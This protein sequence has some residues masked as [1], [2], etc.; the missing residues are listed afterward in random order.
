MVAYVVSPDGSIGEC[1]AQYPTHCRFHVNSDGTTMT[2]YA[3]ET[4]A[5]RHVENEA[6]R[7]NTETNY[8]N[9]LSKLRQ[10]QEAH[11]DTSKAVNELM[12][13]ARALEE[14]RAWDMAVKELHDYAGFDNVLNDP[15]VAFVYSGKGDASKT[16]ALHEAAHAIVALSEGSNVEK[17]QVGYDDA[18]RPGVRSLGLTFIDQAGPLQSMRSSMAGRQIDDAFASSASAA[19]VDYCDAVKTADALLRSNGTSMNEAYIRKRRYEMVDEAANTARNVLAKNVHSVIA[20]ADAA[21][22]RKSLDRDEIRRI[23]VESGMVSLVPKPAIPPNPRTG[24]NNQ[25]PKVSL[26][27]RPVSERDAVQRAVMESVPLPPRR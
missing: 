13:S 26:P 22:K 8:R 6:K 14:D 9:S 25:R 21:L 12:A 4:A 24:R 19:G 3:D 20:L 15:N 10:V 23:A 5:I 18:S 16:T 2:H 17:L 1:R 11:G 27:P 7:R